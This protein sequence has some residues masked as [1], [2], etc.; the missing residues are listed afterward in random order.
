MATGSTPALPPDPLQLKRRL[1][2]QGGSFALLLLAVFSGSLY[3]GIAVQR[4]E[5]QRSELLQLAASA[6]T[7][8]PLIAH[9]AREVAGA[10]K[11]RAE[12][13]VVATPGLEQQRVQWFDSQGR[14]FSEQ[15]SL[16]MPQ[17]LTRGPVGIRQP[18][19]RPWPGGLALEQ[20]VF[21]ER[22]AGHPDRQL[23]GVVRVARSAAAAER[24][25][26][27]LR[28]GL[29]LGGLV[30]M[31]AALLVSRRM[32]RSAFAPLQEQVEALE[33]FTADASHELRH[34]LTALRT[35]LAAMPE[36]SSRRELDDLAARMAR[37]LDDLL[38]LARDAS[39]GAYERFDLIELLDD[40]LHLYGPQAAERAVVLRLEQAQ[41]ITGVAISGQPEHLLRLF[42]NL[43]L[44]AIRHSPRGGTVALAITPM[45]Q[46]VRVEVVDAG[47]GIGP[48]ERE[49]V[50]ER[51]WRGS[52]Q[53]D[54]GG[55]SGLGL[56]IARSIARRHGGDLR[57]GESRPGRCVLVVEL[58][59]G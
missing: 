39:T 49:Q 43:L 33:R 12:R 16:P 17:A 42:T 14:L 59:T 34:P 24:D 38:F 20:P 37:L 29:L 36:S 2:R 8:L 47:P 18:R 6:A 15:G 1:T 45:P 5:D 3:W 57:L 35:L 10:R 53:G 51:F 19:W 22:S 28:R 50:F 26:E 54:A 23:S 13:R 32:L 9:E 48:A 41:G 31:L 55:H 40:L 4:E 21:T 25:L 7:Q 56:A 27:R 52:S 30:A 58:P 11:F 46:A 44:N